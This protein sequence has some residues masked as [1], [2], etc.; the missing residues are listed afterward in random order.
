[1][2]DLTGARAARSGNSSKSIHSPFAS[3]FCSASQI[4]G[5]RS[6]ASCKWSLLSSVSF[7]VSIRKVLARLNRTPGEAPALD[8]YT[9]PTVCFSV[10]LPPNDAVH[11][12]TAMDDYNCVS[13]GVAWKR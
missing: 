6:P 2:A 8:V 3:V 4:P 1:V 13:L 5:H 11:L 7:K 10:L 9:G 12:V